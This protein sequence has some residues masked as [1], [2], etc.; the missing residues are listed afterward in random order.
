MRLTGQAGP[1][2]KEVVFQADLSAAARGDQDIAR[3]C[4]FDR[5]Y[6]LI[7]ETTRVGETPELLAEIRALA[8]Q[9]NI[10]TSYDE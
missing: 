10:R 1:A 9:Y 7:G 4:A 3:N 5:I 2:G 8:K 6:Y